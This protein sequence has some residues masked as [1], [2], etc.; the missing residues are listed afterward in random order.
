MNFLFE[1]IFSPAVFDLYIDYPLIFKI[2]LIEV[3]CIIGKIAFL[4]FS[5]M[6]KKIFKK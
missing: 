2:V 3:S 1:I 5:L 6:M 4:L